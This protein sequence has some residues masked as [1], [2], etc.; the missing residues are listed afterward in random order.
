M[1]GV[2]FYAVNQGAVFVAVEMQPVATT[3][4]VLALTPLLVAAGS[5]PLL[6]ERA[7][8]NLLIGAVLVPVGAAAYLSGDLGATAAGLTAAIIALVATTAASLLGRSINRTA[9]T[10][11]LVTTTVSM[12]VGAVLLLATGLAVDGIVSLSL[13]AL[14]IILW[15]AVVNTAFAFTLWN[16]S[17]RHLGA[18]ESAV[19][20]NT[21]LLQ[22]ALLGWIFLD[23]I[24]TA[25]QWLGLVIVFAG[26]ALAQRRGRGAAALRT[27]AADGRPGARRADMLE[28]GDGSRRSSKL[29]RHSTTVTSPSVRSSCATARSS[30]PATTSGSSPATRRRTPRCWRSAMPPPSSAAG[31]S[32]TARSSSR[33]S[34]A[35]CAPGRWS[36]PA[37]GNSST[38]QPTRR[39]APLGRCMNLVADP[40]LNHR[41]PV[42]QRRR[43]RSLRRHAWWSSSPARRR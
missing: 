13:R 1:L 12:A 5:G 2:V 21:M 33:W 40:R 15:L 38:A 14:V 31:G 9:D 22:I 41:L 16:F 29:G 39:P 32:T 8:S 3:S 20:N 18:G 36:T 27:L 24:P 6:G 34:R 11:P 4:L 7:S 17:L 19:I 25:V 35:R 30:L 42:V 10:A 23:E 37:S 28:L 26:I 43:G